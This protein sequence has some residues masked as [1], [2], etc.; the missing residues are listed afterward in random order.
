MFVWLLDF[1]FHIIL[2]Y[3]YSTPLLGVVGVLDNIFPVFGTTPKLINEN[4]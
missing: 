2:A 3:T 4:N 1:K